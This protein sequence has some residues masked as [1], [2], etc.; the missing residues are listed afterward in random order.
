[1]LVGLILVALVVSAVGAGRWGRVWAA[2][3]AASSLVW[4]LLNKQ[5]EGPILYEVTD[6]RGLVAA[7][8]AGLT[9]LVLAA[10]VAVFDKRS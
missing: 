6:T 2:P 4:L 10:V 7:D 9:G 5:V 3:L 1:M 8:L